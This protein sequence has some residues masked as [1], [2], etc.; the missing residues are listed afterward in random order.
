MFSDEPIIRLCCFDFVS[1]MTTLARFNYII[2][3]FVDII[4]CNCVNYL[5]WKEANIIPLFKKRFKKQVCKV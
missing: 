1:C 2:Y 3:Y 4:L 5:E